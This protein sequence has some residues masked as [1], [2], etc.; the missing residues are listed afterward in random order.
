[1]SGP[2][3]YLPHVPPP[4]EGESLPWIDVLRWMLCVMDDD[5][6]A[7]AFVAGVLRYALEHE[8]SITAKQ[9]EACN[10]IWAR[11]HRLYHQGI[12]D[13]QIIAD[14]RRG[15]DGTKRRRAPAKK[16]KAP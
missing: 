12:L 16:G 7:M 9:G 3:F 1:M 8:G 6:R 4:P 11:M 5:D 10:N 15:A 14:E 2:L 13:C